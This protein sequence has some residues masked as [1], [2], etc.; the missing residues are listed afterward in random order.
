MNHFETQRLR[1]SPFSPSDFA[2]FVEDMLT[3]RRVIEFYYSYQ[4]IDDL[5]AIREK[6]K[7]DFWDEIETAGTEHGLPVWAAYER[8]ADRRFVGWCGLLHGELSQQNGAPELQY[9]IAGDSHGQGYA[10][11][12]ARA[13]IEKALT[14][15]VAD[16]IVA[17]VDIPNRGSIRVL[18][19][20]GFDLIRQIYAYGSEDMYLYELR[21]DSS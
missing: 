4:D 8:S 20:L 13:V 18:E 2:R 16:T 11:E 15:N 21:L 10:T 14:E 1:L 6:A 5:E 19:K 9:M 3:D 12:L 17:T 7:S